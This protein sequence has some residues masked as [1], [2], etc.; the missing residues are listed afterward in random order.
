MPTAMGPLWDIWR[1]LGS[2]QLLW[3]KCGGARKRGQTL[4]RGDMVHGLLAKGQGS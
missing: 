1:A 3:E 4:L 2:A